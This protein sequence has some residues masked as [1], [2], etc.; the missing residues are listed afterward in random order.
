MCTY[1][2]EAGVQVLA[3][4]GYSIV[5][6]T[7]PG[8]LRTLSTAA[9]GTGWYRGDM[10]LDWTVTEAQSPSS[11][12]TTGC[13]RQDVTTDTALTT[14]T[15]TATS[16][17][18]TNS[19]LMNVRRDATAP[20]V[21]PTSTMTGGGTVVN[22]WHTAPVTVGFTAT[23]ETSLFLVD[24][25]A[26][27]T[28]SSSVT[29]TRDGEQVVESP[30]FTDRAGNASAI[31]AAKRTVKVDTTAPSAPTAAVSTPAGATGW[32]TAP[33]TVTFTPPVTRA[34]ASRAAPPP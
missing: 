7:A 14:F 16:A 9:D 5:D 32:H 15:C 17:G 8:I 6:E 28:A 1:T 31:G 22:G 24:G 29:T 3:R 27:R 23:D 21:S 19:V 26:S 33:V 18:G 34:A 13:D 12:T 11:L 20:V 10:S 30:A 2:D 4:K 25:R